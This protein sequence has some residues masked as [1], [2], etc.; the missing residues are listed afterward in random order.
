M[1]KL[2]KIIGIIYLLLITSIIY[3]IIARNNNIIDKSYLLMDTIS[4]CEADF[5]QKKGCYTEDVIFFEYQ[6]ENYNFP[7]YIGL[8]GW[9]GVLLTGD[10]TYYLIFRLGDDDKVKQC[11]NKLDS[12]VTCDNF[13]IVFVF[14]YY[15]RSYYLT[16]DE[17]QKIVKKPCP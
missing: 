15:W 17:T 4:R 14:K 1:N 5:K 13:R 2:L 8:I 6:P 3:L 10:K 11:V 16:I 7:E 12:E 9:P